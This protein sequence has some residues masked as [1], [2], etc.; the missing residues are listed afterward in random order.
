MPV[1]AAV[2]D[3][4]TDGAAVCTNMQTATALC[5]LPWYKSEIGYIALYNYTSIDT[6]NYHTIFSKISLIKYLFAV[7]IILYSVEY[8]KVLGF[9]WRINSLIF[10]LIEIKILLIFL[11][12][13]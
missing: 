6:N 10:E 2:C 4:F 8:H 12:I 5:D 1:C 11:L 3:F 7:R 9:D 13:Y